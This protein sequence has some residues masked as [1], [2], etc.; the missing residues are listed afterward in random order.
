[1]MAE[2]RRAERLPCNLGAV[3]RH[4]D[5][6]TDPAVWQTRIR[7]ISLGGFAL[8][9]RRVEPGTLL[10]VKPSTPEAEYSETWLV[11]VVQVRS[12]PE[13]D[14]TVGCCLSL[15]LSEDELHCVLSSES[16]A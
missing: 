12:V 14:W 13:G 5:R 1:M 7:N 11:R 3:C 15:P 16:A 2:R 9:G 10:W 8:V 6:Q 4:Y